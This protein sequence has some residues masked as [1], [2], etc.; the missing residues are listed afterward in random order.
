MDG[1]I[2]WLSLTEHANIGQEDI[3]IFD[4]L[5]QIFTGYGCVVDLL[6]EV[7]FAKDLSHEYNPTGVIKRSSLN[8]IMYCFHSNPH[9]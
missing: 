3:A 8:S 2:L 6:Y 9:V 5:L 7:T 4:L 1:F